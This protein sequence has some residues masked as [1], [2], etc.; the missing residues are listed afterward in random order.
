MPPACSCKGQQ[1][2]EGDV[3]PSAYSSRSKC[4]AAAFSAAASLQTISRKKTG[5][6]ILSPQ[7]PLRWKE[8]F[9]FSAPKSKRGGWHLPVSLTGIRRGDARS[10]KGGT[11]RKSGVL[12]AI[13]LAMPGGVMLPPCCSSYN[14]TSTPAPPPMQANFSTR[15][16]LAFG[17]CAGGPID[18]Q[19]IED[20]L[21][22]HERNA[23]RSH[24]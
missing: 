18:P 13:Y 5:R 21:R 20:T 12:P 7:R 23:D 17:S 10:V 15:C 1:G 19:D 22:R 14:P 8:R 16:L 9:A 2:P 11:H 6:M 4:R 24:T 3:I